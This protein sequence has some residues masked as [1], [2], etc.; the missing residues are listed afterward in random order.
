MAEATHEECEANCGKKKLST[1][2]ERE[3]IPELFGDFSF[4][5]EPEEAQSLQ[6]PEIV[7]NSNQMRM[8]KWNRCLAFFQTLM[9]KFKHVLLQLKLQSLLI[10]CKHFA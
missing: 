2:V 8:D 5:D 1:R 3:E 7:K 9:L 6:S 4:L 10:T